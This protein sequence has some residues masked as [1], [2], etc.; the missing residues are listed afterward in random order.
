M[1]NK[2]TF[3]ERLM[4]YAIGGIIFIWGCAVM[5]VLFAAMLIVRWALL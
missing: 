2:L 3:T 4:K 1:N 5:L